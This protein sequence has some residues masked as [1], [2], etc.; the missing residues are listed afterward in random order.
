ML[1]EARMSIFRGAKFEPDEIKMEEEVLVKS[2][3]EDEAAYHCE[4][5]Q[6]NELGL[7][8]KELHPYGWVREGPDNNSRR[9]WRSREER[10]AA[11]TCEH[12]GKKFPK[13]GK[14]VR[15]VET[16]HLGLKPLMCCHCGDSFSD[17]RVFEDHVR[18]VHENKPYTCEEQDC[19]KTFGN[20]SNLT[21]HI[22][23]VHL[24]IRP[25]KCQDP[26]CDARFYR[27]HI[28]EAHMRSKHG[29]S[30]LECGLCD[31]QFNRTFHLSQHMKKEHSEI[32]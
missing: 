8:K 30:K 25:F 29:A 17:K 32:C 9:Y 26:D 12:C 15:H 20:Q 14:K 4:Q 23:L 3:A 22:R 13:R 28:M 16:M 31:A 19:G 7:K 24:R 10:E 5:L 21:A 1:H 6:V 27:K 2:E 18:V 11:L